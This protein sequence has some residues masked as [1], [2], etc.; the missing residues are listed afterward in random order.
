MCSKN[1]T[2][3]LNK[4]FITIRRYSYLT[5]PGTAMFDIFVH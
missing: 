4:K 2:Y 1:S 3:S 5:K